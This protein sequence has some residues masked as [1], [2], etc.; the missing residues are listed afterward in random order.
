MNTEKGVNQRN[1]HHSHPTHSKPIAQPRLSQNQKSSPIKTP[2]SNGIMD[3]FTF[4][5]TGHHSDDHHHSDLISKP[6]KRHDDEQGSNRDQALDFQEALTDGE[7]FF[8]CLNIFRL[9]FHSDSV[10]WTAAA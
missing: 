1:S 9:C 4:T 3:R 6:S 5:D 8:K 2:Q 10:M 7:I